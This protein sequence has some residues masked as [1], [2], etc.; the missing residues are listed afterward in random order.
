[1]RGQCICVEVL[2]RSVGD[3]S[4]QRALRAG[5]VRP[6]CAAGLWTAVAA[7]VSATVLAAASC[8]LRGDSTVRLLVEAAAKQTEAR[9]SYSDAP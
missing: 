7:T 6:H 8:S 1:M 9:R 3:R 4:L 2:L 5:C